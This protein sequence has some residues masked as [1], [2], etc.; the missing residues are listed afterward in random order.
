MLIDYLYNL[1]L[2]APMPIKKVLYAIANKYFAL[3]NTYETPGFIIFFVTNRCNADCEHC[4]YRAGRQQICELISLGNIKKMAVSLVNKNKLLITGGEPFTRPDI[5]E[6]AEAFFSQGK[7]K[8]LQIATNGFFTDRIIDFCTRAQKKNWPLTIQ[9][10]LD[11]LGAEHDSFRRLPGIFDRAINTI[12][13]I[14]DLKK[15]YPKLRLA[16][17]ATLT[18]DNVG[19][20]EEVK[21]YL[22]DKTGANLGFA[23]VRDPRFGIHNV[24]PDMREEL[25]ELA[26]KH[27]LPEQKE[28]EKVIFSEHKK[29]RR[30]QDDL[31]DLC[32]KIEMNIVFKGEKSNIKCLAG[33]RDCVIYPN[34]DV[35][36]CEITKPFANLADFDFNLH[37]LWQSEKAELTRKRIQC[38]Y[39]NHPC[40]LSSA[41]Q[42]QAETLRLLANL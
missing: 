37:E 40:H 23:I 36:A 5:Y 20:I 15:E 13:K 27:I 35:S 38:C 17:L 30:L 7:T 21:K 28:L 34:G 24:P 8:K 19:K 41:M 10:S 12:S 33:K 1:F 16:V 31:S 2:A 39:C 9:I 22:A 6:I 29:V 11:Y 25:T 18:K 3:T 32:K 14:Q 26:Q 4:F 42:A